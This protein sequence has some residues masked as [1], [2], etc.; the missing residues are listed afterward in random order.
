MAMRLSH[1]TVMVKDQQEA[2]EWYTEKLG[3]EKRSDDTTTVP[4]MRWLTVAPSGQKEVE[5]VLQNPDPRMGKERATE[6]A[7]LIGKNPTWVLWTDNCF[8]AHEQLASKGVTFIVPPKKELWGVSAV[9][10]DLYGNSYNLL[11]RPIPEHVHQS[12]Y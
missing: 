10:I 1:V 4:G 11:E 3:F 6:M 8:K 2:L 5:I 12:A 9:F 7:N